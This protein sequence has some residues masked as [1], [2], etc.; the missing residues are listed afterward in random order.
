[1]NAAYLNE[2]ASRG[3]TLMAYLGLV[4]SNG[5][6]ITG[7]Q[8]E[9]QAARWTVTADGQVLLTE[10]VRFIVDPGTEIGGWAAFSASSGG[11][12][13]GGAMFPDPETIVNGGVVILLP[14]ETGVRHVS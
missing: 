2:L 14:G 12:N 4:D 13:Y 7:S 6:E 9:R 3:A 1:M 8:Y 11:I 10:E 5:Q